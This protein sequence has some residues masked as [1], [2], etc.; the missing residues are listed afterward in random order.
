MSQKA[1]SDRQRL[2]EKEYDQLCQQAI[3]QYIP[4]ELRKLLVHFGEQ[5]NKKQH[6]KFKNTDSIAS[7]P[8]FK[9][10]EEVVE[11]AHNG[12]LGEP[13]WVTFSIKEPDQQGPNGDTGKSFTI[14]FYNHN[15][16]KQ[17]RAPFLSGN[18]TGS[19]EQQTEIAEAM[20]NYILGIK[21]NDKKNPES[22]SRSGYDRWDD[23]GPGGH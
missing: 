9:S 23:S 5:L 2:V 4:L 21:S 6:G 20:A 16:I 15:S 12:T 1:E 19:P 3:A 13:S 22:P 18:Y 10:K 8:R 11:A 7:W 17:L 14:E